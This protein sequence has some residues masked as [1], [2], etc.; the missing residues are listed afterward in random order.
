MITE[1]LLLILGLILLVKGADFFV[2]AAATIAKKLG[3]SHLVIGLTLVALGT[4]IP[5]LASSVVASLKNS[6]GLV[7][8]NVVGSNIANV[9]LIGGIAAIIANIK[10]NEKM[11]K[12]D[13]YIMLIVSFLVLIFALNM[14]ITWIE[15][16][17]FLLL[18]IAYTTFLFDI[19]PKTKKKYHWDEFIRYF[20]TLRYLITIR[21]MF[22]NKN[23]RKQKRPALFKDFLIIIISGAAVIYGAKFFIESAIF[24][25]KLFNVSDTLIGI[26]LVAI[27]T[28]LPELAVSVSAAIK[29]YGNI[30]IG[31]IIGSNIT[32]ILLILG[33]S[34][35]IIPITIVKT[36][37]ILIIPFMILSSIYLLIFLKSNWEIRRIEGVIFLIV[38]IL[39]ITI[40]CFAL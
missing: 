3:I 14:T 6:P 29:G 23:K 36:T 21:N 1:I 32:N 2:K 9:C 40:S 8:G 26:S 33:V 10:T 25:A 16:I 20:F 27:G 17:I 24:F 30:V 28:S 11:L 12:R 22:N 31:N 35:L 5:E 38:Y 18:Y 34:G 15:S 19:N 13:G 37:L 4:S 7:I 39:F